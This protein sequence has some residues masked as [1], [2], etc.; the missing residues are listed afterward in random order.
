MEYK[1]V[2]FD[3]ITNN[4]Y[5]VKYL[6]E[7][8]YYNIMNDIKKLQTSMLIKDYYFI[9]HENINELLKYLPS[10]IPHD[11]YTFATLNRYTYNVLGVF[12]AWIEY[13][14]RNY[15]TL[16]SSI[17]SKYYDG[18]F[19]YRMMYNL[20]RFMT[21][22]EMAVTVIS[23]NYKTH[24]MSINIEPRKLLEHKSGIQK[25]FV[26]EIKQMVEDNK[27][28]ELKELMVGFG[29]VFNSIHQ[30][31][32]RG[33]EAEIKPIYERIIENIPFQEGKGQL[34]NIEE[35]ETSKHIF[36][37]TSFMGIYQHKMFG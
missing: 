33:I 21:H 2:A 26:P 25:S 37:L 22:C 12:Y 29:E 23:I 4:E 1:I 10:V 34:C 3:S 15:N 11:E 27:N 9:V 14:E 16:F 5:T 31:L 17:K 35:K 6:N 13:C 32:M 7:D 18:C 30:E 28:V 24:E 20:R 19:E 8:D 36:P